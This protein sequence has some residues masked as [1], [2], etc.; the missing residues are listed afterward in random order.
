MAWEDFDLAP[1]ELSRVKKIAAKQKGQC[2]SCSNSTF[3]EHKLGR[4]GGQKIRTMEFLKSVSRPASPELLSSDE[5]EANATAIAP[6]T[7]GNLPT[8]FP[9]LPPKHAYLQTPVCF[10]YCETGIRS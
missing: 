2:S 7:L 5:D 6:T 10:F 4:K 1:N 8:Y 3:S 9:E